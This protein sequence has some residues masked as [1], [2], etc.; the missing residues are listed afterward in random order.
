MM[1][2][3]GRRGITGNKCLVV[4]GGV[5]GVS[6]SN[7][8]SGGVSGVVGHGNGGSVDNGGNSHG[9]ADVGGGDSLTGGDGDEV[10]DIGT[11][12]LGDDVAVL[13]LDGDNLDGGVIHAVLGGDITAS[14]HN[15][16]GH[17]VSDSGSDDG[18]GGNGV[19]SIG[20]NGGNGVVTISSSVSISTS[21]VE[22]ISFGISLGFTSVDMVGDGG[23]RGVTQMV[24]GLLAEGHILNLFS[25]DGDHVADVLGGGNAVLRD[26]DLVDG[27]AVGGG[28]SVVGHG[29][30]SGVGVSEAMGVGGVSLGVRVG[31]AGG[32]SQKARDGNE[33][34]HYDY[35]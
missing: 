34:V 32:K 4:V 22:S 33:L 28:G 24:G 11:G 16:G 23:N 7:G 18:D 14:V 1:S 12:D 27:V 17:R 26:E 10:L 20:S 9:F 8:G 2:D 30:N 29:G 19:V 6:H 21:S 35:L 13:N 15:G 5:S 3:C 31:G 25:V